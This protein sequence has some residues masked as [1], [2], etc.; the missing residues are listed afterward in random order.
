MYFAAQNDIVNNI[1]GNNG[2]GET[3][4]CRKKDQDNT[5]QALAPMAANKR[6][7]AVEVG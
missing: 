1:A 2:R 5:Q 6:L 3:K 4:E 7:Q